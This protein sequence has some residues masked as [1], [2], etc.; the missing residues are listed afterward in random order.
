MH[1]KSKL[2][3]EIV[4]QYKLFNRMKI[5]LVFL[6]KM[7]KERNILVKD[8]S[9]ILGISKNSFYKLKR[10]SQKV[11]FLNL[12]KELRTI[13]EKVRLIKIELKYLPEYLRIL[14]YAW[15]HR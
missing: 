4:K 3:Y 12:D 11:T 2:L 13:K 15:S 9:Y 10:K 6:E 8:L 1:Y 14:L 5:T 7:S